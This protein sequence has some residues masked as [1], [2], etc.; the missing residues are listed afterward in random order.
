MFVYVFFVGISE[1]K[2][3]FAGEFFL[4]SS[5]TDEQRKGL[6][7]DHFLFRGADAMQAAWAT[8]STGH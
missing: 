4:H 1:L 3:D 6:I 2:G 7:A 5:M 8:T